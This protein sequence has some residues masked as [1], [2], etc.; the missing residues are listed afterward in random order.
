MASEVIAQ[1]K[2]SGELEVEPHSQV[3]SNRAPCEVRN[4]VYYIVLE[5][6]NVFVSNYK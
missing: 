4:C 3:E 5:E 2:A 1:V 6:L